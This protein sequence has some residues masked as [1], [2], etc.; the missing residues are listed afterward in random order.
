M[1]FKKGACRDYIKR[2]GDKIGMGCNTVHYNYYFMCMTL[3]IYSVAREH[4]PVEICI[5]VI[6]RLAGAYEPSSESYV[7][8]VFETGTM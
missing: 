7:T 8:T 5:P 3:P 1:I 4:V 2:K 6:G